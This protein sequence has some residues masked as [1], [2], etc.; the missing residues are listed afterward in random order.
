MSCARR[1]A[2]RGT[3]SRR[4]IAPSRC[5]RCRTSA[6]RGRESSGAAPTAAARRDSARR[7]RTRRCVPVGCSGTRRPLQVIDEAI[8]G[9]PGDVHLQPL[10]RRIDVAR[11]AA[12]RG[13]LAEHVPRLERLPQRR[14]ESRARPARRTPGSGTRSAARTTRRRSRSR[15]RRSSSI[16]SSKS[17]QTKYGSMKRS[18]SS[19]PQ[20]TSGASYGCA[21]EARDERAQQQLLREAHARVR[22]H[23]ERAQLEQAAAARRR[24]RASTACRCRTRR[25]ACCR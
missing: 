22:R 20:R 1:D 11:R 2:S 9:Q 15:R 13:L 3:G 5:R 21:P 6:A 19:V 23:L 10:D 12:G 16:T 14:G 7:R 25:G 18:C 17:C 24:C 4:A 8:A